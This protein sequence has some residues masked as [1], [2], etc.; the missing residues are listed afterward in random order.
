MFASL[1]KIILKLVG[2]ENL[3]YILYIYL[4]NQFRQVLTIILISEDFILEISIITFSSFKL[5][6]IENLIYILY[7]YLK[8]QFRQVYNLRA[9]LV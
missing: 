8:N 4:K 2:I 9:Q 5:V 1:T 7:I 6:G 3:I